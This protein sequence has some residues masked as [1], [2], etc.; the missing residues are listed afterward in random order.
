MLD[1]ACQMAREAGEL[2]VQSFMQPMSVHKKQSDGVMKCPEYVTNMDVKIETHIIRRIRER[3]PAHSILSE[4][5]GS[6]SGSSNYTWIVD[7]LDGTF[8]YFRSLPSFSTSIALKERDRVILGVV[9]NPCLDELF[10]TQKGQG[11]FLGNYVL[12][13]SETKTL[14]EALIASSA[15]ASYSKAKQQSVLMQ[16]LSAPATIRILGVPA[17]DLCYVAASR[18]DAR[19]TAYTEPWDHSAGCLMIEEAGGVVTDWEGHPWTTESRRLVASNGRIHRE[20]LTLVKEA[21]SHG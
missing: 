15:F 5:T 20:L 21:Y 18:F 13:V 9:Y 12:H 4:E 16:L 10:W 19:I 2:L 17:L 14:D 6:I 7:P 11:A 3:Y 1:L 8:H